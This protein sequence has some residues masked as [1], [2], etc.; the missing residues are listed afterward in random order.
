MGCNYY[1]IN[2][3]NNKKIYIGHDKVGW[4]FLLAIYPDSPIHPIKDIDDWAYLLNL[5]STRVV[6]ESGQ[7]VT[8][9]EIIAII[10]D[11]QAPDFDKF[12]SVGDYKRAQLKKVNNLASALQ[13]CP[14]YRG[15]ITRYRSYHQYT[16]ANKAVESICGLWGYDPQYDP[17]IIPG[18]RYVTY[19]YIKLDES[20]DLC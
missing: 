9:E 19:D 1:L 16:I 5:P 20:K 7:V 12:D 11:R 13:S 3:G 6:D 14:I 4:N 2:K 18:G 10:T 17:R 8:K 15:P